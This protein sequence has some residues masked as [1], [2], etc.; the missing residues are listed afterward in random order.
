[1]IK[2]VKKLLNIKRYVLELICHLILNYCIKKDFKFWL[3][4]IGYLYMSLCQRIVKWFYRIL[5]TSYQDEFC[6]QVNVITGSKW[7]GGS[8][9]LKVKM[10]TEPQDAFSL[11]ADAG[12]HTLPYLWPDHPVWWGSLLWY[13][14]ERKKHS[15]VKPRTITT[16]ILSIS[17]LF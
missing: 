3:S 2:M 13:P 7:V 8:A 11:V 16:W 1:M 14:A 5:T 10:R 17:V 6:K 4:M 9:F 15:Q 12:G